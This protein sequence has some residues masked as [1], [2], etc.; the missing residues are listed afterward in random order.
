M[1]DFLEYEKK[2]QVPNTKTITNL[3]YCT[4]KTLIIKQTYNHVFHSF[5]LKYSK[6]PTYYKSPLIN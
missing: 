6:T 3:I 4:L 5:K 1:I 2:T